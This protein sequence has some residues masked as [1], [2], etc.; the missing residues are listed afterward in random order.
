[1]V[2]IA[3][4]R[5]AGGPHCVEHPLVREA[6]Q[7][8]RSRAKT[9]QALADWGLGEVADLAELI[10]SELLTNALQHGAAPVQLRLG[11]GNG[12]LR[13]EVHDC[14]SGRPT[15]RT[16]SAEDERGRGLSLLHTLIS[17]LDGVLGV[18]DDHGGPGKTVYAQ[19]PVAI[20]I[21]KAAEPPVTGRLSG[22]HARISWPRLAAPS[23]RAGGGACRGCR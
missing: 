13:V 23:C 21:A 6:V 18:V 3:G 7:V 11:L 22:S 1:M 4:A 10:V 2:M 19:F 5:A 9:G 14:G 15:R 8:G 12:V 16:P 20:G 17:S